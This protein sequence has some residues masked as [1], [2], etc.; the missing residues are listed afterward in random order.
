MQVWIPVRGHGLQP[1]IF[2]AAFAAS[3][4]ASISASVA[5][6]GVLPRA[7]SAVSIAAKRRSNF[8]LVARRHA[9]RIG[10]EV[11]G[12]VDHGEKQIAD[13]GAAGIVAAVELGLDLVGLLA[14]LGQH[15]A[16]VV[17]VEADAAGLVLQLQRAG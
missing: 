11:A 1:T 10:A 9:F 6:C 16:R 2:S 3:H 7:A 13:L 17:P 5:S 8:R 15:A 14:D 12:E 4:S